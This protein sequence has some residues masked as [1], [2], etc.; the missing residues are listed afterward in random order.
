MI[1]KLYHIAKDFSADVKKQNISAFAASTAFF[2]FLSLVPMLIVISAIIPHTP[3][4]QQNLVNA[5]TEITPDIADALAARL[6]A[7]VYKRSGEVLSIAALTTLWSAGKGVL[8]LMRG[9]NAINDTEEHRNYVE[10]RLIASMYTV[11]MLI[12]MILSLFLMVFGEQLVN[13]ILYRVPQTRPLFDFLMNFRFLAVWFVLTIMFS[14]IYAYVP[15]KK[16]IFKDQIPG[17]AFTAVVWSVYSWG[18]ALFVGRSEAYSVY[19]SLSIVII[20]MVWLYACM[21]IALI[22]AYINKYLEQEI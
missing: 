3:L 22:G 16:L 19:G 13:L 2:L 9:L 18:F 15:D 10:V 20:I 6:V 14:A 21:Y 11:V 7:E 1:R 8:A 4:T 17:A 5:V 12:I